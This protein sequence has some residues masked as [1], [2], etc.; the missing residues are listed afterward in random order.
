[1][2]Y[3][4]V[5]PA[6]RLS[7]RQVPRCLPWWLPIEFACWQR[8]EG[9]GSST[10]DRPEHPVVH[11]SWHDAQAYCDWAGCRLPTEAEWEFAARGGLEGLRFP[12]GD[13]TDFDLRCNV[14]R[15][16]FPARPAEGWR[17]S[18]VA[19]TALP[20]NGHG[21]HHATGNVWQWCAD[22]FTPDYHSQTAAC[23]PRQEYITERRSQRGGSFLCH[24]SYCNRY[25][26]AGRNGNTPGS[27]SG[28]CGFRVVAERTPGV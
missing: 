23:D 15:G 20:P 4:Q 28:N 7:V 8:P 27:T 18:P 9:P 21:L 1:M 13:S 16:S 12:W 6:I 11:V 5:D 25:R 14:W 26:V 22:W 2:F 17:P 3:L 19:V 10:I 24:A